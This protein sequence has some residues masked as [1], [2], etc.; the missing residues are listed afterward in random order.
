M[1]SKH[2]KKRANLLSLLHRNKGWRHL[3]LLWQTPKE[4]LLIYITS[5]KVSESL[6]SELQFINSSCMMDHKPWSPS[7]RINSFSPLT[8]EW[9]KAIIANFWSVKKPF[10]PELN[11]VITISVYNDLLPSHS[12]KWWVYTSF[13]ELYLDLLMRCYYSNH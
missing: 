5:K 4:P 7:Y 1:S 11:L 6:F 3:W 8:M 10:I 13:R 12:G 2:S 9:L